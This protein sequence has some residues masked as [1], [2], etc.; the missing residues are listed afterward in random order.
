M[1]KNFKNC[2][3]ECKLRRKKHSQYIN[4]HLQYSNKKNELI[5][6]LKLLGF[7]NTSFEV[8]HDTYFQTLKSDGYLPEDIEKLLQEEYKTRGVTKYNKREISKLRGK[9]MHVKNYITFLEKKIA[10]TK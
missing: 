9:L 10:R 4:E 8:L 2:V 6:Q 7:I 3:H 5:H 1:V